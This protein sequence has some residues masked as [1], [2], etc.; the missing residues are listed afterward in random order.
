M[1]KPWRSSPR[2]RPSSAATA[3]AVTCEDADIRNLL[4][5]YASLFP[6]IAALAPCD[7]SVCATD[8]AEHELRAERRQPL[9]C[10]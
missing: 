10:Y 9:R 7:G 4:T 6:V 3:P 5:P 8:A 1:R 2:R